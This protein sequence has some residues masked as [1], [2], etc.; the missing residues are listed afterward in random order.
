MPRRFT[1][2]MA[3]AL[4]AVT[5]GA[6]GCA[7]A[8]PTAAASVTATPSASPTATVNYWQTLNGINTKLA[9]DIGQIRSARTPTAVSAAVAAAES[10][11]YLSPAM[12]RPAAFRRTSSRRRDLGSL[13]L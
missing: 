5:A 3:V 6:A 10:D 2:S 11:V 12:S 4:I 9:A 1:G 7:S 8:K 13:A